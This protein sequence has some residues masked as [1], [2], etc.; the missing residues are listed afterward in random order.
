MEA[1]RRA[2]RQ[3]HARATPQTRGRV[4]SQRGMIR[5]TVEPD[6]RESPKSE[7]M[8]TLLA[9]EPILRAPAR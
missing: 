3:T 6:R 8:T 7:P 9:R 5:R 4:I 2:P 1:L